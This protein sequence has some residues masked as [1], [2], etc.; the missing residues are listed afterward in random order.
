[1]TLSLYDATIPS[2]LQV[3]RALDALLD[4][5]E[6]FATERGIDPATLIDA[7]LADDMLPFG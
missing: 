1:M 2:N 7:K 4:K 5:A 3:L 6:G